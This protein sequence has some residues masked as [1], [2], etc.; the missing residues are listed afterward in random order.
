[1]DKAPVAP[2]KTLLE[3][4]TVEHYR[5][6]HSDTPTFTR[7]GFLGKAAGAAGLVVASQFPLAPLALAD[8][9]ER[10][11]KTAEPKPIPGGAIA[12]GFQVHHNPLPN[13]PT[14][15]LSSLND[16]SEIGDFNGLVLDTMIR[17]LGT[18]TGVT[19][20]GN[21]MTGTLPFRADMGAMQGEYVG[22]DGKHHHGSFVFV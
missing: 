12:F 11:K 7:R 10:E 18:G 2:W 19:F 22:E 20:P 6:F 3:R 1:M 17:G 8:D 16:P 13:D 21:D 14:T 5:R 9:D 15:P 4:K